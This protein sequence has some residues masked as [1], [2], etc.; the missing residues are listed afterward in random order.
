[1]VYKMRLNDRPFE[2]VKNGR[3][4]VELRLFD[5]KRRHLDPR[6]IIIFHRTSNEGD[7]VTVRVKALYRYGTFRELFEEISR[8][9]VDS[10]KN[11]RRR[12]RP[13]P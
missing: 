12:M 9:S 6:D 2:Q 11:C 8:C 5:L 10:E 7:H 1:M 13:Q 3:K 4:T